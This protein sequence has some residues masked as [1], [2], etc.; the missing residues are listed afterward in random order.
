MA[1]LDAREIGRAMRRDGARWLH[2][3]WLR[4]AAGGGAALG[5]GG[6]SGVGLLNAVAPRAGIAVT[7]D[8]AYAPG[9]RHSLD[10]YRPARASGAPV[11]VFIYG[12]G[13]DEGNKAE[14]AF[15]GRALA[16]RGYLAIVPDYRLY[17]EVRFPSFLQDNAQAVRWAYDHAGEYGGDRTKL[18]LMGHSA[19]AYNA[20]ML[21]LDPR[22]LGAVGLTPTRDVR[23]TVGLAGP[24]DFLPLHSDELKTIFGP[25][26]ERPATQPINYVTGHAPPLFLGVDSGD[27]VVLPKNTYNLA[28]KV[29]AAGGEVEVRT[30]DHLSHALLVGALARPVTVLAPVMRDVAVLIDAHTGPAPQK[31]EP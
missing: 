19:G 3:R 6:C 17:P 13:W 28:T 1:H 2:A 31:G 11:V 27:T 12:G 24:Y 22:W 23:A 20:M 4:L 7:H 30:Y 26:A 5:I 8:I 21:T 10:I 25:P 16:A 29:R 9:D 14:Y 15:V 18:V